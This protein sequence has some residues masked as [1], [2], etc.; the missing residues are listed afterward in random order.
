MGREEGWTK[1]MIR[2]QMLRYVVNNSVNT[3]NR[4]NVIGFF[5]YSCL[6]KT[7]WFLNCIYFL[8]NLFNNQKLFNN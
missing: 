4:E 8:L 6:Y 7:G 5:V 3:Q 1:Q 2:Q